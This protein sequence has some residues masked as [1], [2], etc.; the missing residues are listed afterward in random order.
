MDM[1]WVEKFIE[2]GP[3]KEIVEKIDDFARNLLKGKEIPES[4]IRKIFN[5]MKSL[6]MKGYKEGNGDAMLPLVKAKLAYVTGKKSELQKLREI[7]DKGI[8]HVLN[9]EDM[10][11]RKRRFNNLMKMFEAILAYYKYHK[12]IKKEKEVNNE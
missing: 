7:L 4:Q 8:N 6:E 9:G 10:G 11:E 2:K 1:N 12:N 3:S 5:E